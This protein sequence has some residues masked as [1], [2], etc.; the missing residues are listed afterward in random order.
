M[1]SNQMS[2]NNFDIKKYYIDIDAV[3]VWITTSTPSERN[4]VTTITDTL[5]MPDEEVGGNDDG[6]LL[7]NPLRETSETKSSMNETTVTLRY[8]IIMTLLSNLVSPSVDPNTM[9]ATVVRNS[10]D[11]GFQQALSFNSLLEAGILKE[12]K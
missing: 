2:L 10:D 3:M 9:A 1:K 11:L 12:K 8:N 4:V 7:P 5:P 6:I